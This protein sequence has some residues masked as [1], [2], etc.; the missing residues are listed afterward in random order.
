MKTP[1]STLL[2]TIPNRTSAIVTP[3]M[4][5]GVMSTH[6]LAVSNTPQAHTHTHTPHYNMVRM[7]IALCVGVHAHITTTMAMMASSEALLLPQMAA[8]L[9]ACTHQTLHLT[10]EGGAQAEGDLC[11]RGVSMHV[12][13]KGKSRTSHGSQFKP[14]LCY[15]VQ[16]QRVANC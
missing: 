5:C 16:F 15:H 4:C 1:H 9:N 3:Q 6:T 8:A 10:G 2:C 7:A 12:S 14:Y 11:R 13:R